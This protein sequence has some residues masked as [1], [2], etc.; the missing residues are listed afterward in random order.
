M[1]DEQTANL[2]ADGLSAGSFV[3]GYT[4]GKDGEAL[5][6]FG[7]E[8][9]EHLGQRAVWKLVGQEGQQGAAEEREVG[10]EI[11]VAAAGAVFAQKDIAPPVVADFHAAPVAANQGEPVQWAVLVW[12]GAGKIIVRFGGGPASFFDR[13]L[14]AQDDQRA[15]PGEVR[16]QRFDG[17]G[18]EL[19][20]FN[21][22]VGGV[23][24][25]KKGV[26]WSASRLWAR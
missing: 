10:Q 22:S 16:R 20:D 18:M 11:G 5:G 13:A 23:G 21:P 2:A 12:P 9:F 15:G 6:W 24:V 25:G 7:M 1:S 3:L 8:L 26:S 17:E 14:V 19:A 4:L